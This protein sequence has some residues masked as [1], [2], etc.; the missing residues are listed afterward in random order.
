MGVLV[1][2]PIACLMISSYDC[3]REL[4]STMPRFCCRCRGHVTAQLP[5]APAIISHDGAATPLPQTTLPPVRITTA[6]AKPEASSGYECTA[7]RYIAGV[8]DVLLPGGTGDTMT[9]GVTMEQCQN[10]CNLAPGCNSYVFSTLSEFCGLWSRAEG[11]TELAG[12]GAMH[13]IKRK[14]PASRDHSEAP[15]P[16]GL[17]HHT[18]RVQLS[19][20]ARLAPPTP[21]PPAPSAF[22]RAWA[23]TTL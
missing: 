7:D 10:E 12:L 17:L 6:G 2:S 23:W 15:V 1:E 14:A 9:I 4:M 18:T 21:T 13:C 3:A 5:P 11:S 8:P 16:L 22:R 19:R 20:L